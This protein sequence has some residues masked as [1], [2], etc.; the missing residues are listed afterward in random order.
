MV[1]KIKFI[2]DKCKN[3]SVYLYFSN[4]KTKKITQSGEIK[5]YHLNLFNQKKIKSKGNIVIKQCK[6]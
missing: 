4:E 1:K 2:Y 5:W 3:G 6:Q